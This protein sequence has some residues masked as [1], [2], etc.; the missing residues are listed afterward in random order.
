MQPESSNAV[1]PS[2]KSG[3]ASLN[4]KVVWAGEGGYG[5]LTMPVRPG[6]SSP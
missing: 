5:R 2:D 4:E 1:R 6:W 3:L